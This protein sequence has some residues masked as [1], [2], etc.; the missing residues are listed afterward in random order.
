[1]KSDKFFQVTSKLGNESKFRFR[2]DILWDYQS[3]DFKLFWLKNYVLLRSTFTLKFTWIHFL[4]SQ[5]HFERIRYRCPRPCRT[6]R[7]IFLSV[8]REGFAKIRKLS[9]LD[10]KIKIFR[11]KRI[12]EG[13]L[14]KVVYSILRLLDAHNSVIFKKRKLKF[15]LPKFNLPKYFLLLYIEELK[16]VFF[17]FFGCSNSAKLQL[18][19]ASRVSK[20]VVLFLIWLISN[21]FTQTMSAYQTVW[22]NFSPWFPPHL[23]RQGYPMSQEHSSRTINCFWG[24]FDVW[25]WVERKSDWWAED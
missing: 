11:F 3:P 1:M 21:D 22:N 17:F 23:W 9:Y 18:L 12:L 13:C 8:R 24:A 5:G 20:F 19:R 10:N 7:L 15:N 4:E 2:N 16:N 25:K 14:V 6:A